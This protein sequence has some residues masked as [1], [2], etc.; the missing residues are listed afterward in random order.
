MGLPFF[1]KKQSHEKD[2][3]TGW[4]AGIGNDSTD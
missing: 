4:F 1:G 3:I 2:P